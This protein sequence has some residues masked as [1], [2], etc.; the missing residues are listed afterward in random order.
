MSGRIVSTA[1]DFGGPSGREHEAVRSRTPSRGAGTVRTPGDRWAKAGGVAAWKPPQG[2]RQGVTRPNPGVAGRP[3]RKHDATL[4]RNARH[5]DFAEIFQWQIA[6]LAEIFQWR[7][8]ELRTTLTFRKSVAAMPERVTF[9]VSDVGR[10]REAQFFT[11]EAYRA[12]ITSGTRNTERRDGLPKPRTTR[13]ASIS[14]ETQNH[15]WR[16]GKIT[17]HKMIIFRACKNFDLAPRQNLCYDSRVRNAT[18]N[19]R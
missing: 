2:A 19:L 16:N 5:W 18:K 1:K 3:D 12:T 7:K 4:S 8:A 14:T 9:R 15:K 10:P 6:E 11:N 13:P 17:N